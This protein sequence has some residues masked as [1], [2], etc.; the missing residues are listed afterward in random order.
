MGLKVGKKKKLLITIHTHVRAA[1]N[2]Y[3]ISRNNDWK[4]RV[5]EA[6]E[7]SKTAPKSKEEEHAVISSEKVKKLLG[8]VESSP[9]YNFRNPLRN[10]EKT[11][12]FLIFKNK[13]FPPISAEW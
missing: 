11:P 7:S 2:L 13:H 4:R 3:K 5:Q 6:R 8:R 1:P 12:K 9:V 10:D